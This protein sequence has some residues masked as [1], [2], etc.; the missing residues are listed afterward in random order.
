VH[1]LDKETSGLLVVAKTLNAQT[2]LVQQLQARTVKKRIS[3]DCMGTAMEKW[4]CESAYWKAPFDS[5]A[6]GHPFIR[7]ACRDAL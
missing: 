6:H 3:R 2:H 1:R 4:Y 7:K 5:N